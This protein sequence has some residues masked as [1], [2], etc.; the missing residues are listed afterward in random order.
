MRSS[1][2]NLPTTGLVEIE[3]KINHWSNISSE[4]SNVIDLKFP[5]QLK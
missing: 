3:F 2:D 1:L 4:N 5:K